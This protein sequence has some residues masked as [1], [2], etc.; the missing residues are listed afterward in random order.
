[1]NESRAR[2]PGTQLKCEQL[3]F[4]YARTRR[5]EDAKATEISDEASGGGEVEAQWAGFYEGWFMLKLHG[6]E[7]KVCESFVLWRDERDAVLGRGTNSY[8]AFYLRGA[9]EDDGLLRLERVYGAKVSPSKR[10]KSRRRTPVEPSSRSLRRCPLKSTK[11]GSG[12]EEDDDDLESSPDEKRPRLVKW[13]S[14]EEESTRTKPE[15]EDRPEASSS[16]QRAWCHA[17]HDDEQHEIYEG[18][19]CPKSGLRHGVGA[20]VYVNRDQQIY[21]GEW[22]LGREHGR[23]VLLSRDRRVVFDGDFVDGKLHGKGV[24]VFANGD[25]Y[26]GDWRENAR[27]G[28]G[29]YRLAGDRGSYAG[30]WRDNR[31][32]GRG[33]FVDANGSTY[34]GDWLHDCRHGRGSLRLANGLEYDGGFADDDFDGRG[35]C[36]Y[37]DGQRYEGLFKLGKKDGRGTLHWPNGASYEGRFKEDH[38]DGQGTLNISR[39]TAEGPDGL[40]LLVPV[41]L[42]TDIAKIHLKAG[43]DEDGN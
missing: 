8:G 40:C 3:K 27:H 21:E 1:M 12:K 7:Q 19:L 16:D 18:E 34:D 28:V 15:E 39:P 14:E 41:D 9:L 32:H 5:A 24:C 10:S 20:C 23:G 26:R 30:D 22:R 31:R 25:V 42:K 17:A 38:I 37:P 4:W 35:V 2:R 33:K 11:R 6:R 29:E 43:F 36:T 13:Q